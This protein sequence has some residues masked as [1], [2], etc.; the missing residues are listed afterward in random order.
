[1]LT[2]TT[3]IIVFALAIVLLIVSISKWGVHPF[4]AIMGIALILAVG[5]GIPLDTIVSMNMWGYTPGFLEA[6]EADFPRF[7]REEVPANP[8]KAEMFLPMTIGKMLRENACTVKVLRTA[9]KWFGVTYA[10]DKP[11]V[12][13]ALREMTRQ[14]LY[15]DGL[16]K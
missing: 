11:V 14:G 1:M 8:A 4:L 6:V 16:W 5:I 9:D 3:L 2:G 15:P 12:V 7:L 13:E 10:A